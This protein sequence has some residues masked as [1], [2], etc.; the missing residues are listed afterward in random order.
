M[1]HILESRFF[2]SELEPDESLAPRPRPA[3]RMSVMIYRLPTA[4]IFC[5]FFDHCP[6]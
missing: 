1:I 5:V 6:R 2:E 3:L 4:L